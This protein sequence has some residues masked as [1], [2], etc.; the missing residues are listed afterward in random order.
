MYLS[1]RKDHSP[2]RWITST[3]SNIEDNKCFGFQLNSPEGTYKTIDWANQISEVKIS[4]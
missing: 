2:Y 4:L 1:N 3:N